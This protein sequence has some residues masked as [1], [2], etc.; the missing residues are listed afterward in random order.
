MTGESTKHRTEPGFLVRCQHE[1]LQVP[2]P[3]RRRRLMRENR[4]GCLHKL[5]QR[6]PCQVNPVRLLGDRDR[7]ECQH[8]PFQSGCLKTGLQDETRTSAE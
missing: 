1:A 3:D 6:K 7:I 5:V 4:K 2:E 8:D